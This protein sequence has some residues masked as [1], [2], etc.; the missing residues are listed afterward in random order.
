MTNFTTLYVTFS[1]SVDPEE[2]NTPK[3]QL[4]GVFWKPDG[5]L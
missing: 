2:E 3:D 5:L 1:Q 4:K